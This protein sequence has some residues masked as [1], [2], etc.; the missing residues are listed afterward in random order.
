MYVQ[1][2]QCSR[3]RLLADR[4]V[5]VCEGLS[6]I[7]RREPLRMIRV[8]PSGATTGRRSSRNSSSARLPCRLAATRSSP[9]HRTT[10]DGCSICRAAPVKKLPGGGTVEA[11]PRG[12]LPTGASRAVQQ[13]TTR[14]YGVRSRRTSMGLARSCHSENLS[15]ERFMSPG[16]SPTTFTSWRS[17]SR[18][19]FPVRRS[20]GSDWTASRTPC[21]STAVRW[22][23][24]DPHRTDDGWHTIRRRV[25]I[26]MSISRR[27]PARSGV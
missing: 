12:G 5:R 19:P 13:L 8:T 15:K 7:N 3:R 6:P 1:P 4:H 16:G 22:R 17:R 2:Q 11:S 23:R 18:R 27:S 25:G 10:R 9:A 21:S 26:S 24:R 20:Y 14:A